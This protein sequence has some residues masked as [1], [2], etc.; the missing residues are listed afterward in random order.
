M[1]RVRAADGRTRRHDRTGAS[2]LAA[3]IGAL[4][5]AWLSTILP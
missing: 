4:G 5:E 1:I 2:A 3:V